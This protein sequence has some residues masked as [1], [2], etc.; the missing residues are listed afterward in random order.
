MPDHSAFCAHVDRDQLV[1]ISEGYVT[2]WRTKV[3]QTLEQ[4]IKSAHLPYMVNCVMAPVINSERKLIYMVRGD[5]ACCSLHM[6]GASLKLVD[7]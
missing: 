4:V 1:I 5:G 7:S 2:R 6:S 3:G